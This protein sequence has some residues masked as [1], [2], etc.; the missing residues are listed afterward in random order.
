MVLVESFSKLHGQHLLGHSFLT[1]DKMGIQMCVRR[2]ESYK[3][4]CKSV[5][6]DRDHLV[7]ELNTYSST[8]K[9][10]D[11][12]EN[13][14]SIYVQVNLT[15][16]TGD[17]GTMQCSSLQRC[18]L[19]HSGPRCVRT[20]CEVPKI[21]NAIYNGGILLFRNSME[22]K[23]G[24]KSLSQVICE[25]RGLNKNITADF[26]CY[27]ESSGW[28]LI[29]RSQTGL[30]TSD[31]QSFI[32]YGTSDETNENFDDDQCA[33]TAKSPLCTSDYRT[34]AI[35][36]WESMNISQV[37]V[38]LHK[39]STKVAEVVFNGTDTTKTSWFMPDRILS[40]S[41]ADVT[42]TQ[43]YNYFSIQGDTNGQY[44]WRNFQI[45][46]N[47]GGCPNDVFWMGSSF[48]VPGHGC[49]QEQNSTKQYFYCPSTTKC[50]FQNNRDIADVMTISIKTLDGN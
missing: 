26:K 37:R 39:S 27:K 47:Y 10:E 36:Q 32:T 20:G 18:V 29:Y 44:S 12:F 50:S 25:D 45:W 41:W 30:N 1:L 22:C 5:N 4:G 9:P 3:G 42:P 31:Y 8:D 28:I 14:S 46:H 21:K 49:P 16:D 38:Q 17:C 23:T 35:D 11:M 19:T 13:P 24:Y 34:S 43:S 15:S 48:A 6:F 40:S 7:C 2:C 33:T